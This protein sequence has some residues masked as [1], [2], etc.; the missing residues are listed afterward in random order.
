MPRDSSFS[1]PSDLRDSFAGTEDGDRWLAAL[2]GLVDE[3]EQRP[4][5]PTAPT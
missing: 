2:P 1:I 3:F 4:R 5:V